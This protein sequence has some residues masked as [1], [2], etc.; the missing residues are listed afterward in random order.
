MDGRAG[1]TL[2]AS[3][4]A[5]AVLAGCASKDEEYAA[6]KDEEYADEVR[7][8]FGV[9]ESEIPNSALVDL[10]QGHCEAI[11]TLGPEE[12]MKVILRA[13]LQSD[14]IMDN[15][16]NASAYGKVIALSLQT[17][18]PEQLDEYKRWSESL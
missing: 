15:A 6:S 18:C 9:T 3:L 13:S 5:L 17:Y 8:E 2:S 14:A 7:A 16:Q 10:A 11:K 12:G 4:L 1:L